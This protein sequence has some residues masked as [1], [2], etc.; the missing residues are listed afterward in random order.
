MKGI[1][2]GSHDLRRVGGRVVRRNGADETLVPIQGVTVHAEERSGSFL[3]FSPPQWPDWSWL[4]PFRLARRREMAAATTDGQGRFSIAIPREDVEAI[5]CWRQGRIGRGDFSRPRLLD[6][7]RDLECRAQGRPPEA[8]VRA[9]DFLSR[10]R[11]RVGRPLTDRIER[12]FQGGIALSNEKM[13]S[14]LETRLAP[15]RP[16]VSG[17]PQAEELAALAR[18]QGLEPEVAKGARFGRWIGPFWRTNNLYLPPWTLLVD[19]PDITFRVTGVAGEAVPL[20]SEGFF[21]VPWT[22]DPM[23]ELTLATSAAACPGYADLFPSA[24][25]RGWPLPLPASGPWLAAGP[26]CVRREAVA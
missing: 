5:A 12:L 3:V 7:V 15:P 19:V 22:G 17:R 21:D 1:E 16:A 24:G 4:L 13:D 8:A 25:V 20:D 10:C 2:S 14:L 23:N 26:P 6:L 18:N 9:T 11:K